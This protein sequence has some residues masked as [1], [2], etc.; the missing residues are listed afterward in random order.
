MRDLIEQ[1]VEAELQEL[2]VHV[3]SR[4]LANGSAVFSALLADM[5][6]LPELIRVFK[7]RSKAIFWNAMG[8]GFQPVSSTKEEP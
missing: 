7:V 3:S 8:D 6:L 5:I 4:K 2:L 1:A